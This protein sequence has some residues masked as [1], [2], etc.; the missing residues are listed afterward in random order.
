MLLIALLGIAITAYNVNSDIQT[1]IDGYLRT[2][3]KCH[4]EKVAYYASSQDEEDCK[5][6]STSTE[7]KK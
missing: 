6:M 4:S 3:D 1:N 2:H 7:P 5:T